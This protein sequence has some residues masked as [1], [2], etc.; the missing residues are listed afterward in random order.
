MKHLPL[1]LA[2]LL[3]GAAACATGAV[4]S[5]DDDGGG[6]PGD[7]GGGGDACPGFDLQSD[8][9]HCG[10]C[11][12]ACSADQVCSGG[13]C[14]ASCDPP[15]TKC[16]GDGGVVCANVMSD[17]AHCGS[18]TTAC[19]VGD[20]GGMAPGTGNPEGGVPYDGGPGWSTG[21][22]TCASGMCGVGCSGGMTAC[23]DG[24]C[25]DT[26]NFHDRC[27]DCN[28][29]C[30]QTEWCNGGHCCA[31]NE[32]YCS[33]SCI[34]VM[35]DKSNCGACGNACPMSKPYCSNGACVM[36]CV[37]S[38]QRQG[39][40]TLQSHTTTGCWNGNPCAQGTYNWV[41]TN[42]QSFINA[43][44]NVVCSGTTACVAHVGITTYS[45]SSNCQGSWDVYC[46]QTKV[47]TID[48]TN[49]AC[50]GDAM[51]NGC[52]VTFAPVT[53]T[54][55]KF[56]GLTGSVGACCGSTGLHSMITA[57]SAW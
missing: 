47:G 20:A 2:L 13:Q 14:K 54:T 7:G 34:D 38:G 45:A 28:T 52:S 32:M 40:N 41:S 8:P 53:C 16:S 29:Q 42:G 21:T 25:Y 46:D 19:G 17:P 27:G 5:F 15:T 31:L 6:P 37:P 43:N 49:K 26:K 30:M 12:H 36:A 51:T 35:F 39:F 55:V 56:V 11:S 10:S 1:G 9:K 3:L 33:G 50:Q 44:E 48:T 23:S 24:I 18:C 22:P 4:V 57:V